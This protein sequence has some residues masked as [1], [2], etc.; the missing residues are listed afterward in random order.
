MNHHEL[1]VEAIATYRNYDQTNFLF[2]ELKKSH[3]QNFSQTGLQAL[4]L[5]CGDVLR[6]VLEPLQGSGQCLLSAIDFI[7]AASLVDG[8]L[9]RLAELR[10]RID[11][12]VVLGVG[13]LIKAGKHTAAQ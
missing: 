6:S 13:V 7:L 9:T 11:G 12:V 10:V 5:L 4:C 3:G 2:Q 8:V 1:F